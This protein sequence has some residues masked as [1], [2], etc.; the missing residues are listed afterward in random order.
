MALSK[1]I[2][3]YHDD[4]LAK[5][6]KD[7]LYSMTLEAYRDY[8]T[9]TIPGS[10]I[11]FLLL[12][13]ANGISHDSTE[14]RL[15]YHIIILFSLISITFHFVCIK[16]VQYQSPDTIKKWEIYFSLVAISTAI[17]WAVFSGLSLI[18]HGIDDIT[19]VYL[20]FSVG[21]A[22]GA[23][24]SNF[25]WHKIAQIYLTL[26]LVP[27]V[28]ILMSFQHSTIAWG[29][30]TSITIYY[31]FLYFQVRRSNNEYW[32]ALINTKQLEIQ[33]IELENAN[34]AKS[35][36]LSTMSHELRTPLTAIIGFG[37]LIEMLAK[38][39]IQKF[40]SKIIQAGDHLSGLVNDI[41]DLSAIESGKLSLSIEN[42]SLKDALTESI[43]LMTPQAEKDDIQI[44]SPSSQH[45]GCSVQADYMR[46]KQVLLNLLSNAIK[47]NRA[48]GT[49]TVSC[50][51]LSNDR[52]RV[53]V[54]DTG[55][56]MNEEQLQ[57]LFQEFNRVG[58]EQ[59]DIKGTGIGL[60]ITKRLVELMGGVIG[61]ESNQ[62]KGTSFW[63][64]LKQVKSAELTSLEQDE[65]MH[66][67]AN[68]DVKTTTSE[69]ILYIEDNPNNLLLVTQI[70]KQYSPHE[71]ISAPDG[72]LGID[73]AITQQPG[74]ILLD[75][76]L[77]Y[78][79]GY[80]VLKK[81]RE[82]DLTS[83]IPVIAV[84]ANAMKSDKARAKEAGFNDYITKPIN[85]NIFLNAI[86]SSLNKVKN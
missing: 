65:I 75:I 22:S 86:N 70:I 54:T 28:V 76:N 7:T 77:P 5:M 82:N 49:I 38:D 10:I 39:D 4:R 36:F 8:V 32:K 6:N 24:A 66:N 68:S 55:T 60:V 37:E 17:Y 57:Q 18:Q 52:I 13:I 25:I 14:S 56:G 27:P 40:A 48:G 30:S 45:I 3:G 12:V 47:Y 20:L 2:H 33:T 31:L 43:S 44:I 23:A 16:S 72:R 41:L 9:R 21:I 15:P 53:T 59:T 34:R 78:D 71:I 79:D 80:T 1:S 58:A 11:I 51:S 62:G 61:V 73:L 46:L 63:F 67:L 69:K 26:I 50:K 81:L 64:E 29:L 85:F 19:M 42:V 83:A 74:L 35:K 84:T